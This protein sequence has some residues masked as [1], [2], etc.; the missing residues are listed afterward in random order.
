MKDLDE[1]VAEVEAM[2]LV[3]L[4]PPDP[5]TRGRFQDLRMGGRPVF[6]TEDSISKDGR[7]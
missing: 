6:H 2:A 1:R 7:N 4:H 5:E 3:H